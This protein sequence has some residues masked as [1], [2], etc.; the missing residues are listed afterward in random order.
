M[1]I[2]HSDASGVVELATNEPEQGKT[3]SCTPSPGL[4]KPGPRT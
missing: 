1:D 3:L 4:K 2:S